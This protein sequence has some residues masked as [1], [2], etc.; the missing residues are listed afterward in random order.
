MSE[1]E[2]QTIEEIIGKKL[3]L[4][5]PVHTILVIIGMLLAVGTVYGVTSN[6]IKNLEDGYVE[7]KAKETK[8]EE[9]INQV[10]HTN[11]KIEGYLKALSEKKW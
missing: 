7:L 6:R 5:Q 4:L 9:L 3:I 10:A 1:Q 8:L 11:A 2:K